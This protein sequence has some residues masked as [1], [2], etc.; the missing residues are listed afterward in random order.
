M[1]PSPSAD[2]STLPTLAG[3]RRP[4]RA[5]V[6]AERGG[7]A[8]VS[9][10]LSGVEWRLLQRVP[11]PPPLRRSS[12]SC[13]ESS[14]CPGPQFENRLERNAASNLQPGKET[15]GQGGQGGTRASATW[16]MP[17]RPTTC[18]ITS[19]LTAATSWAVGIAPGG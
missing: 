19:G 8:R 10:P 17:R 16:W 6:A 2:R 12:S 11:A 9:T 13:G 18:R 14:L 15:E 7:G 1:R 4:S 5:T 3:Y